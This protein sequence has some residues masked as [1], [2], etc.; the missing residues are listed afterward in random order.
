[1]KKFTNIVS[2]LTAFALTF[3]FSA[4][5]SAAAVNT[6]PGHN[7]IQCFD[8][9]TDGGYNGVCTLTSNGSKGPATLN[10]V[11]DDED[12]Y[13]NYS[14]VY[15]A[16]SNMYGK[17]LDKVG[18]LSFSYSGDA[19]TAGSPRYSVPIDTDADGDTD[20]WAFISALYCNDGAGLVD[21][22]NDTTC[23]I[24]VGDESFA[25]WSA[26]VAAHPTWRIALTDNYVFI[27]AD[28]PG[29]WTISDVHFGKP[30]K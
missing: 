6:A 8:G 20:L 28:D 25:N 1:M 2:F 19:A 12:P 9:T 27:V 7:K 5:V 10:N 29:M 22:V 3:A 15:T 18:K 16:N 14:G 11:D 23:T 24:Y 13:N 21:A 26:L 4:S 30:G 17:T